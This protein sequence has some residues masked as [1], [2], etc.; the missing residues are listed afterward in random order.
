MPGTQEACQGV[1][2]QRSSLF[3][4]ILRSAKLA[5][6]SHPAGCCS[7]DTHRLCKNCSEGLEAAAILPVPSPPLCMARWYATSFAPAGVWLTIRA[8]PGEE[9]AAAA[10]GT[11]V[12]QKGVP[13]GFTSAHSSMDLDRKTG[14]ICYTCAVG[15]GSALN[16]IE[17][18]P[19]PRCSSVFS[20]ELFL[21]AARTQ[22]CA[23]DHKRKHTP[24]R[25]W[26]GG[27]RQPLR[28][29]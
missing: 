13:R 2:G 22:H 21:S 28:M 20:C 15:P 25:A 14:I 4:S 11:Q 17:R 8:Y 7:S 18:P 9:W 1:G 19:S 23:F 5:F 10:S 16:R 12:L 6:L 24:A 26:L 27:F 3:S 29:P